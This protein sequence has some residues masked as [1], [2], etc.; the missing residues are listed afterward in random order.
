MDLCVGG[1]AQPLP[2]LK[3]P[4]TNNK[5]W[6][7]GTGKSTPP[8]ATCDGAQLQPEAHSAPGCESARSGLNRSDTFTSGNI[9]IPRP[10]G[11]KTPE[12][13]SVLVVP[14]GKLC[15]GGAAEG[16][17]EGGTLSSGRELQQALDVT[18]KGGHVQR[19]TMSDGGSVDLINLD[20]LM[21]PGPANSDSMSKVGNAG[22]VSST[23]RGTLPLRSYLQG[24]SPLPPR[25]LL[26]RN[27][28]AQHLLHL[29]NTCNSPQMHYT[30]P[31]GENPFGP[32]HIPRPGSYFRAPPQ[33]QSFPAVQGLYGQQHSFGSLTRP[34]IHGRPHSAF[35]HEG[36]TKS[37]LS[38]SASNSALSGSADSPAASEGNGHAQTQDPFADLLTMVK[39]DA[40][41]KETVADLR[42]KWETFE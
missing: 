15:S 2:G 21:D 28:F 14:A 11:R 30:P 32:V 19:S 9:T 31:R 18:P 27:P 12:L 16:Q 8:P 13:G 39:Q 38:S 25:P 17:E 41:P 10:H 7:T 1:H 22:V 20:P 4:N 3:L 5:L 33:P 34:S 40:A 35:P 6:R 26:A 24:S 36:T 23:Y 42:W 37:P 29:H